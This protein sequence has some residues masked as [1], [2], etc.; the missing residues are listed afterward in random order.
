MD[1]KIKSKLCLLL[2]WTFL[3]DSCSPIIHTVD[4]LTILKQLV[5][6]LKPE[7]DLV[8]FDVDG[9]LIDP[10][11]IV[12]RRSTKKSALVYKKFFYQGSHFSRL[13][14]ETQMHLRSIIHS[15]QT[16]SL[17]DSTTPQLIDELQRK[18][19]KVIALTAA[20]TGQRGII[21]SYEDWRINQL[22]KVGID[23]SKAFP[24]DEPLMLQTDQHTTPILAKKGILFAGT[25]HAKS[26]TLDAFLAKINHHPQHIIFIDDKREWIDDIDAYCTLTG[27]QFTGL[28]YTGAQRMDQAVNTAVAE[29][30]MRHLIEN[31]AWLN[32]AEVKALLNF[33]L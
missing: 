9:V 17:I 24:L 13:S 1:M 16:S 29:F 20:F 6:Q 4:N 25:Y 21:E 27:I 32:D 12:L 11:D 31:E 23:F 8:I 2:C 18:N 7:N 3:G 10:D 22:A 5:D 30:Q 26:C 33:S 15:I 19:I 28:H 14:Y